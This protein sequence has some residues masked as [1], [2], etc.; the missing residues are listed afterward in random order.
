M[1]TPDQKVMPGAIV[2]GLVKKDKAIKNHSFGK[3]RKNCTRVR[4]Q[5]WLI[6]LHSL[7]SKNILF[8][9]LFTII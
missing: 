9:T 7:A 6:A 2:N 4:T 8:I 5:R 1:V 3:K